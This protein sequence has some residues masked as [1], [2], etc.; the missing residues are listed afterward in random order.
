MK[1][2]NEFIFT[3]EEFLYLKSVFVIKDVQLLE[4]WKSQCF[5]GYFFGKHV[6][7]ENFQCGKY[8]LA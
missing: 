7:S 6:M 5:S 1:E 4:I 2:M 3:P 8:T